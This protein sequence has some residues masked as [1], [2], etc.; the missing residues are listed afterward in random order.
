MIF[1]WSL[2]RCL[3]LQVET[4]CKY[5]IQGRATL[6]SFRCIKFLRAGIPDVVA[7]ACLPWGTASPISIPLSMCLSTLFRPYIRKKRVHRNKQCVF[8]TLQGNQHRVF[9]GNCSQPVGRWA[10][11]SDSQT[12]LLLAPAACS[13][14]G[15]SALFLRPPAVMGFTILHFMWRTTKGWRAQRKVIKS[16]KMKKRIRKSGSAESDWTKS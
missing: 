1:T 4:I 5:V 2:A 6:C 14:E 13:G 3:Y 9:P 12:G 15:T 8:P 7:P 11:R 10:D 16:Q